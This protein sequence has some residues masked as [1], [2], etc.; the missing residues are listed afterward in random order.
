MS[1]GDRSRSGGEW[2]P[3]LATLLAALD[4]AA[5]DLPDRHLAEAIGACAAAQAR[6]S[7][8]LMAP[9]PTAASE[10]MLTAEQ[11]AA[12]FQVPVTQIYALGRQNRIPSVTLGKYRRFDLE[13]VRSALDMDQGFESGE[14]QP[15]KKRNTDARLRDRATA[16]Q[17]NRKTA[18]A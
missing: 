3:E 14:L 5:R 13:A 12:V 9:T 11:I 15:R 17:P 4:A 7:A 16:Q 10:T 1:G 8:R 6:L 18:A 2:A